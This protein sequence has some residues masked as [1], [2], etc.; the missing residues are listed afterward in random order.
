MTR[1]VR[2][3]VISF[4]LFYLCAIFS[5]ASARSEELTDSDYTV[6]KVC[7]GVIQLFQQM[8][9]SVW[10]GYDLAQKPFIVYVPEKWAL[11][12]NYSK[13]TDGFTAYPHDWPDLGTDVLFYEGQYKHLAGQL[14]FNI[15]IDTLEV[16]A[17]SFTGEDEVYFFGYVVHEN[18]HQYQKYGK[19]RTFG[20]IPWEREQRYPILDSENTTLACLEMHI[21]MDAIRAAYADKKEEAEDYLKQFLGVRD[22][23]WKRDSFVA[24]YEQGQ[25]I[26]EGTARYVETKSISLVPELKYK[27]SLSGLTQPISDDFSSIS[28]PDIL[29]E[30][31]EDRMTGKSISPEAMPRYRIYPVG[32]AQGFLLDYFNIDWK[33][34]AQ[35]AGPEFTYARLFKD[36]LGIDESRFEE[37]LK[38]AKSN[39]DYEEIVTLSEK[40]IQEYTD[41]FNKELESFEAQPGNRVE[42]TLKSSGVLRSRSS[43]AKKWLVERGTKELCSHFKIYSLK[44]DHLLFQVKESR[45][46]EENDWDKRI[47]KVIF[48]APEISSVLLNG[49]PLKLPG[50]QPHQF[51]NIEIQGSNFELSYSQKGTIASI[52]NRVEINLIP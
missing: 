48:F 25:E 8:P 34:E 20:E 30:D 26:N 43:R 29:L 47:R 51:D 35:K 44:N 17:V 14:A 38:K 24:R 37:H 12:L 22:F 23:R 3:F 13:E 19:H 21:L 4:L 52:D 32:S 36:D 39:Y 11:L 5:T 9:D 45:L 31:F 40:L 28:M 42:I 6:L 18:F 1:S 2:L 16:A 49:K 27:S 33:G 10:P 46:L 15:Q 41:G 50:G 7:E